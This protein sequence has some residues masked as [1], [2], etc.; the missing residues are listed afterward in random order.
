MPSIYLLLSRTDTVFA[1]T[2]Y[3]LTHNQYTHVSLALDRALS[4]MYSFARRYEISP[5]PAGFIRE[6]LYDGVCGRCGGADS[7][8]LKLPV[9]QPVYD[10]ISRRLSEMEKSKELYGYDVM[11]LVLA[12][13]GIVHQRKDKFVCSQFV[14]QVL[15]DAGAL[16]MPY[17]PSLVR[18][19][20]FAEIPTLQVVY[21]GPLAYAGECFAV[22]G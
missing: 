22:A 16:S 8:V 18:P 10:R 21:K 20:D 14:A 15:R 4:R 11:G 3:M 5:L 7:M 6:S 9:S 13:L 1:K 2:M 19:Q 17:D 12:A